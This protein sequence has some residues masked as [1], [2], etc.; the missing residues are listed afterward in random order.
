MGLRKITAQGGREAVD[1]GA[2]PPTFEMSLRN[3]TGPFYEALYAFAASTGWTTQ[4]KG[5]E[6]PNAR[7]AG[8][9]LLAAGVILLDDD[10]DHASEAERK[11]RELVGGDA[12]DLPLRIA[13]AGVNLA[14]AA[15]EYSLALAQAAVERKAGDGKLTRAQAADLADAGADYSSALLAHAAAM[16][17]VPTFSDADVKAAHDALGVRNKRKAEAE[18]K[19]GGAQ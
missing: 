5:V 19:A 17:F 10:A 7:R 13:R 12:Y 9:I 6:Q 1:V 18:R 11:V 4:V 14:L 2:Y 3:T 15:G 8:E 16:T